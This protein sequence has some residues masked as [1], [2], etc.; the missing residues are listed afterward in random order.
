MI[1]FN[2]FEAADSA[3]NLHLTHADEDIFERG[4][5]GANN[6]L[7]FIIDVAKNLGKGKTSLTVKWDGAPAIFAGQDPAD[8]KFF[9]GTK[10]VFNKNPKLYKTIADIDAN[11][12][13][14]KAE[15]LK[16]ALEELPNVG[17]PKGKVLQGD[18]LWTS[19]DLKYETIDG[20]RYIT[21]HPNTIV[22]AWPSESDIGKRVRNARMGIVW[23]T[24]YS[25]RGDLSTFRAKFGVDASRLRQTRSCWMDDAYFKGAAV[26]FTEK[27]Y[28][29]IFTKAMAAK[30]LIGGFDKIVDIMDTIPKNAQGANVKTFINQNIRAGRFPNPDRAYP[31]YID[32]LKRYWDEKI[33]AKLKTEKAK[34]AKK[35]ALVQLLMDIHKEFDTFQRAFEYV[36]LTNDAKIIITK[37]LN[38]IEKQKQFVKTKAGFKVTNPEGFVAIDAEAG[39]AVKFVDRLEF[40][41]FNFSDEY[42]KGWQK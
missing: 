30:R 17:I 38:Q 13:G 14:G 39:E 10:S 36:S 28:S 40:S 20:V 18:M 5:K 8:G 34:D 35:A 15:K 32:Y 23:H 22:Y 42:I 33:L 37:K 21:C 1:P 2:L 7:E 11:E 3:Q 9:V 26:A 29:D 16:V 6:A 12:S 31:E 27:E 4:D 25:G 19:G 24:T 41:H